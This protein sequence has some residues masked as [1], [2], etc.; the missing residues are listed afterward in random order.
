MIPRILAPLRQRFRRVIGFD[1]SALFF[2]ALPDDYLSE[3]DVVLKTGGIYRDLELYQFLTGAPTP[4]GCWSE[5][6]EPGPERFT[7]TNLQ[8]LSLS[9]PSFLLMNPE[10]RA[11]T[12]VFHRTPLVSR[13][14]RALGDRL[15]TK[16]A[17]PLR[18]RRPPRY[19]VYFRGQLS[20][21]QR[22]DAARRLRHSSLRWCGG[23]THI[24]RYVQGLDPTAVNSRTDDPILDPTTRNALMAQLTAENLLA[25]RLN[26]YQHM[27]MMRNCKA[28]LSVSGFGELCFFMAEAWTSRRIL[29]CQDLSHVR[30]LFPFA[31]GRNV[32]YCRPDLTDLIDILD[33]IECNYQRYLPIAEQ[34]YNDWR[35]WSRDMRGVI[36]QGFAPLYGSG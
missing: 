9:L 23:I 27:L 6:R 21:I 22:L 34:G 31:P 1:H 25:R 20:H 36:R 15:L 10:Y 13:A 17:R 24:P 33:D 5:K 7:S 19:T 11:L 35:E 16:L 2:P 18:A 28:V 14:A 32:V 8:K 3:M 30:T 29:V 4:D 26:R 12:R